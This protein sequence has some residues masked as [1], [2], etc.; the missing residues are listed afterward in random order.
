MPSAPRDATPSDSDV[1]ATKDIST[2]SRLVRLVLEQALEE[3]GTVEVPR[4]GLLITRSSREAP[5]AA[6]EADGRTPA[7]SGAPDDRID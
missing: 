3:G 2:A 1:T 6:D 4:L 7:G 5:P